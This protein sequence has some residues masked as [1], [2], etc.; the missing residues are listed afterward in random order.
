MKNEKC[1]MKKSK[2]CKTYQG[3]FFY[4]QVSKIKH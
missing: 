3:T 4:T 1:L 2:Y